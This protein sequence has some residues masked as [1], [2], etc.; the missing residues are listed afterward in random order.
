MSKLYDSLGEDPDYDHEYQEYGRILALECCKMKEDKSMGKAKSPVNSANARTY[1]DGAFLHK[2]LMFY[3]EKRPYEPELVD[4][5]QVFLGVFAMEY[6]VKIKE[7]DLERMQHA[8][9][10]AG[11]GDEQQEMIRKAFAGYGRTGSSTRSKES[12]RRVELID[13]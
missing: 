7:E 8:L 6:G 13:N 3:E 9:M 2:F 4:K 12:D 10:R 11:F 5:S 1:F